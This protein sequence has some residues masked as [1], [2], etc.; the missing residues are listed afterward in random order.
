MQPRDPQFDSTPRQTRDGWP[1]RQGLGVMPGG[2]DTYIAYGRGWA[3]VSNTPFREYKHW[4]H[5]GG[6]ATPLI[7]HWPAGMRSAAPGNTPREGRLI[8][9]P[10]QLTDILATCLDAAGATY[11][12]TFQGRTITPA[13]GRSLR[14][15][16][17]GATNSG[18]PRLLYWEH[19]GNRA[20]RDGRW[21]LVAKE[22][23]PW[24][25]YDLEVDR[26]ETT[27]LAAL[28]PARVQALSNR[29][30]AWAA[31][32]SVLPLGGWR[33]AS[34][35][36]SNL[37][38]ATRFDLKPGQHLARAQAPAI[39]RR[40][41][42]IAARFT[43]S[44]TH[45]GVLVAQGG[46]AHGYALHLAEGRLH[47]T[48]RSAGGSTSASTPLRP[49]GQPAAAHVALARVEPDGRITLTLDDEP[50][51][52]APRKLLITTMPTDGLDVGRDDGGAVGPYSSPHPFTGTLDS[53]RIEL[54][55]P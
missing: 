54:D 42:R 22:N 44:A 49:S 47:F 16:L 15:L 41:F 23:Q 11:P 4:T 14:P 30:D 31:R 37:N 27:N 38:A 55:T 52:A 25:L 7:V 43:A 12:A 35:G 2:P 28:W 9:E 51:V 24:E 36:A 21:K 1:V 33:G 19:E 20:V 53:L 32:S 8:T 26:T 6:I 13:E 50:A 17:A 5:E 3:N 10:G 34:A 40:G 48:V 45:A 29:W 46:S 18:A 39:A